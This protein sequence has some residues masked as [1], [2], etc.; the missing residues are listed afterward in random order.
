[1]S[2][3]GPP[4]YS[5]TRT[6]IADA[7][8]KIAKRQ[9]GTV[10]I[11]ILCSVDSSD[12]RDILPIVA[13]CSGQEPIL[14]TNDDSIEEKTGARNASE[15]E[16][17]MWL[18]DRGTRHLVTDLSMSSGWED[19]TIIGIHCSWSG[20]NVDNMCLRTVSNLTVIKYQDIKNKPNQCS[21]S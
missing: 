19:S 15:E 8:N 3:Y 5:C 20:V 6:A 10:G 2:V 21:P 17:K 4:Q 14:Y 18:L 11:T 7:I 12:Y 9:Q 16:M 13:Q 1:M